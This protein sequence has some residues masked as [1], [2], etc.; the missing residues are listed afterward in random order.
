MTDAKLIEV[1]RSCSEYP[2]CEHCPLCGMIDC[3]TVA[4][5]RL[6]S[7]LVF[8]YDMLQQAQIEIS[9]QEQSF[10]AG[11][12]A[13]QE[14]AMDILN[15]MSVKNKGAVRSALRDAMVAI[16]NLEVEHEQ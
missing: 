14:K 3:T 9:K 12:L 6:E 13:M 2:G 8:G 16:N 15:R 4:A 7:A 5:D 1:L 10:E 11:A